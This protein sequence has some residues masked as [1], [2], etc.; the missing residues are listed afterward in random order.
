MKNTITTIF[1]DVDNTLLDFDY[2]MR[3][4]LRTCFQTIGKKITEEMIDSYEQINDSYWK[5][6]E[7]GEV[8]R[9]ELLNGRFADFF[10]KYGIDDVDVTSFRKEYETNLG[11]IYDVL[12]DSFTICKSLQTK[13]KQYVVTNG[14]SA[15]QRSKL[16]L[17]G[18]ADLMDGLFI[19]QE[20]GASKPERKF[21][22]S[23][24]EQVEEKDRS[25]ILIVGDSLT[26]DIKGGMDA[27]IKTCWYNPGKKSLPKGY[28]IDY[29]IS[30][31]EQ[32]YDLL[33]SD[34]Q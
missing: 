23:C 28:A 13:Q 15:V 21:F 22:E 11:R 26:S 12:D 4:S 3:N 6:L 16:Q 30:H 33:G 31:L 2:S 20:V 1:W 8:T 5:R 14:I 17:S 34:A 18:F 25:R 32:I 27:G 7:L 29:E 19:S 9:E 10:A 24:L